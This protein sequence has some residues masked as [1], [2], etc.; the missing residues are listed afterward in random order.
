MFRYLAL[1]KLVSTATTWSG[2]AF[3]ATNAAGDRRLTNKLAG[4]MTAEA[5]DS[6]RVATLP[7]FSCTDPSSKPVNKTEAHTTRRARQSLREYRAS[8]LQ[9]SRRVEACE[10]A[11][12]AAAGCWPGCMLPSAPTGPSRLSAATSPRLAS[13]SGDKKPSAVALAS[14]HPSPACCSC[15]MAHTLSQSEGPFRSASARSSGG[16]LSIARSATSPCASSDA[17]ALKG[18]I[19]IAPRACATASACAPLLHKPPEP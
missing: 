10:A 19:G 6:G 2:T 13:S 7:R 5:A 8:S 4:R 11:E 16:A 1:R 15:T 12:S 14:T 17:P 9:L 3:S 18:G